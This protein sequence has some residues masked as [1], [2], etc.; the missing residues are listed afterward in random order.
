MV[1][2]QEALR[3]QISVPGLDEDYV[4]RG[5]IAGGSHLFVGSDKATPDLKANTGPCR[6]YRNRA[7][8]AAVV[9]PT[10]TLAAF[11]LKSQ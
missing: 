3:D 1:P 2:N 9:R 4:P 11:R 7:R 5:L 10:G 6:V 8:R